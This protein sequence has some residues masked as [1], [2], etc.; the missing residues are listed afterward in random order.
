MNIQNQAYFNASIFLTP[1]LKHATKRILK[2]IKNYSQSGVFT[3]K[4]S[5]P[6]SRSD[7]ILNK[8]LITANESYSF[9]HKNL[10]RLKFCQFLVQESGSIILNTLFLDGI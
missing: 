7:K 3:V 4:L 5:I 6:A 10:I 2:G 9:I 1:Q 8:K